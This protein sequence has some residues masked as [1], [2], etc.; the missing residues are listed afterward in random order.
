MAFVDVVVDQ[1]D[2]V[3]NC[4]WDDAKCSSAQESNV[5]DEFS[6]ASTTECI[7]CNGTTSH[8]YNLL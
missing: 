8:S 3:F 6:S 1:S 7:E 5:G 4:K 2:I